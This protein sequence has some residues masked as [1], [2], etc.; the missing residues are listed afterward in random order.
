MI[1]N[2]LIF[3]LMICLVLQSIN[4][5]KE[6]LLYDNLSVVIGVTGIIYSYFN[7]DKTFVLYGVAFTFIFMMLP[8]LLNGMGAGDVI[9]ATAL[10]TWFPFH[11]A[12]IMLFGA[13]GIGSIYSI[14]LIHQRK[15]RIPLAPCLTVGT[16]VTLLYGDILWTKYLTVFL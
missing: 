1:N 5:I 15:T 16:L 2:I 14:I 7:N 13:F 12:F 9:M 11:H 6:Q 8:Y 3:I 4:D 10:S